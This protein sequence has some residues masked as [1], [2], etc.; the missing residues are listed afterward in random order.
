M[1]IPYEQLSADALHGLIEDFVTRHGTDY[2][3]IEVSLN[4][5]VE[6]VLRQLKNGD[7]VIAYNHDEEQCNIITKEAAH[8]LLDQ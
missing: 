6:Q 2:G 8:N 1:L 5:K 7:I 4:T 3:N